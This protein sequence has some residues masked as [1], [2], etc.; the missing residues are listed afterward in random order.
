MLSERVQRVGMSPTMKVAGTA[1]K[2]IAEGKMR[3]SG[4]ALY[5]Y[6][7]DKGLLP[8]MTENVTQNEGIFPEVPAFFTKA[9]KENPK[10]ESNFNSLAPSYKLQYLGWIMS[11]KKEETQLRRLEEAID[12]LNSGKKLGMK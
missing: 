9:L 6:A 1:K 5:N 3:P 4:M 7:K 10:A 2:M 11:G 8:D 12:L